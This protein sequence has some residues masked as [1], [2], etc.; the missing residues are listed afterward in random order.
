[1]IVVPAA[2]AVT[3]SAVKVASVPPGVCSVTLSNTG[4]GTNTIYVGTSATVTSSTGFPLPNGATVTVPGFPG[5][6]GVSL[7]AIA[8]ASGNN[9]G[10]II[11]TGG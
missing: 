8:G 10:V 4:S 11:S 6:T 1:M 9:L 2:V 7:Y 3:N 5:S